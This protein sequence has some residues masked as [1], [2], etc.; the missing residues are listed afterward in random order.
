MKKKVAIFTNFADCLKSYSPL[1][2]VSE[3]L[4]MFKE[5]GYEP[6]LVVAESFSFEKDSIFDSVKIARIPNVSVSIEAKQDISFETDIEFLKHTIKGI[7]E[8]NEIEVIL[9]HDLI[10]LPDYVKHRIACLEIAKE[11]SKYRW[12]HWIHSATNPGDLI[13]ERKNFEDKYR[14][15]LGQKF[16]NA[17][18]VFPNAYD[19][20]RVARNFGYEEDEVMVVPHQSDIE[21]LYKLEPVTRKLVK[22]KNLLEADVIMT[23]P[24]RLDRGKQPHINIDITA[25]LNN[26]LDLDA[27]IIFADFQST[28][29]DKVIYREEM[30]KRAED[31]N[32]VDKVIFMTDVAPELAMECP[33]SVVSDLFELSNFF[34]LPSMS[35]TYSLV[36]QEAMGK[37]NFCILN[38]DFAPMR[39]IYGD[40]AIYKQF[41]ANIG[42]DGMNG[43]IETTFKPDASTY[44]LDIACYINYVLKNNKIVKGKTWVRKERNPQAVFKNYLEPL[45]YIGEEK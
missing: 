3:Q 1:I 43:T 26:E 29:G 36:A 6:L 38:H 22:D 7:L 41:S 11:N 24:L 16:P 34:I 19:V 31:L 27:R 35:E 13:N 30:K 8:D 23:Y 12:L 20:P 32:I 17:Y 14:E 18:V 15:M 40:K 21:E 39:S 4:K 28:G 37:G 2:I 33:K 9:T 44:Y 25:A 42:F 5:A 45:L 10:F